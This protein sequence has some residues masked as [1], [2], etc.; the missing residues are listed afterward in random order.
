MQGYLK[1]RVYAGGVPATLDDLKDRIRQECRN[2]PQLF[3][4]K[5]VRKMR[6]RARQC[7][8]SLGGFLRCNR[9]TDEM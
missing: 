8:F 1:E 2:I 7:V 4:K 9:G 3:I 5:V 6:D